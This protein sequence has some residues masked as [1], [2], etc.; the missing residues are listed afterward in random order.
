MSNKGFI[1]QG[2]AVEIRFSAD[3]SNQGLTTITT[4]FTPKPGT[5]P[6]DTQ[7]DTVAAGASV[8]HNVMANNNVF[9]MRIVVDVPD[10]TASGR[11]EVIQDGIVKQNE[12]ILG[13][14]VWSFVV[15]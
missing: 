8:S 7:F 4:G 13:D 9:S 1:E 14:T 10:E 5:A 3:F 12:A 6:P 2:K 15:A 11:L